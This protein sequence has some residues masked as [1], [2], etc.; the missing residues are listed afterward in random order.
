MAEDT[1]R[2]RGRPP[3]A[4][5][6]LTKDLVLAYRAALDPPEVTEKT[7]IVFKEDG[8]PVPLP[9]EDERRQLE[10]MRLAF[11][12]LSRTEQ[13]DLMVGLARDAAKEAAKRFPDPNNVP[14]MPQRAAIAKA[15]EGINTAPPRGGKWAAGK[16]NPTRVPKDQT[17][18]LRKQ[19]KKIRHDR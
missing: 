9:T 2:R 18:P 8:S 14:R 16:G 4:S 12:E 10:A 19:V 13:I 5:K 15:T 7:E 17:S 1:K 6:L 11:V 3:G